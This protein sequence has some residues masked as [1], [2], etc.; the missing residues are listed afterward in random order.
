MEPLH[1]TL[2]PLEDTY[3]LFDGSSIMVLVCRWINMERVQLTMLLRISKLRWVLLPLLLYQKHLLYHWSLSLSLSPSFSPAVSQCAGAARNH[4][5]SSQFGGELPAKGQQEIQQ[6][7]LQTVATSHGQQSEPLGAPQSHIKVLLSSQF[8]HRTVLSASANSA[9]GWCLHKIS[10][11]TRCIF[12]LWSCG[13]QW[14]SLCQS[15]AQWLTDTSES[16]RQYFRWIV[17]SAWSARSHLQQGEG[18]LWFGQQQQR[19]QH[20]WRITSKCLDRWDSLYL[21]FQILHWGIM[22]VP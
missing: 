5:G 12:S 15:H 13:A 2:Q 3:Q 11:T 18:S 22:H 21:I 1:C 4:T 7:L 19:W 10:I 16:R 9:S 8:W 6:W 17:L 14:R 20:R